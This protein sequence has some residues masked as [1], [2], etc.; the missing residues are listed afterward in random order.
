MSNAA[1]WKRELAR[2]EYVQGS[3]TARYDMLVPQRDFEMLE[4]PGQARTANLH[5]RDGAAVSW[6]LAC[7]VLERA[8]GE[9]ATRAA[10]IGNTPSV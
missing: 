3:R 9:T 7:G 8:T 4:R 10:G 1:D 5:R 6:V 2:N